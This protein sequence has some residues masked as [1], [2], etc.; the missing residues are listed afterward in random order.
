VKTEF[1]AASMKIGR[2]VFAQMARSEPDFVSSDCPIAG[3]RIT[4]GIEESGAAHRAAK[5]HPL[6]LVRM[7]YGL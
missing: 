7:A 6:T 5:E 1:Y 2:P 4:Q 3:R